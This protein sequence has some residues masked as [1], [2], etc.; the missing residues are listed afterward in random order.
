MDQPQPAPPKRKRRRLQWSL[1]LLLLFTAVCAVGMRFLLVPYWREATVRRWLDEIEASTTTAVV[2]PAWIRKIIGERFF[3]RVVGVDF[4]D[5][6][7]SDDD[8]EK[9]TRLPKL[10][11]VNL[12]KAPI[13]D[14]ALERLSHV[15]SLRELVL[16]GTA[17]TDDGLRHVESLPNLRRLWLGKT[18]VTLTALEHLMRKRPELRIDVALADNAYRSTWEQFQTHDVPVRHVIFRCEANEQ[19]KLLWAQSQGHAAGPFEAKQ[20]R[21][22]WLEKF[23]TRARELLA[24]KSKWLRPVDV[25]TLEAALAETQ[26]DLARFSPDPAAVASACRRGATSARRLLKLLTADLQAGTA[27]PFAFDHARDLATRLLLSEAWSKGE[28]ARHVDLLKDAVADQKKLL[29]HV[30]KLYTIG[31]PGGEPQRHALA[32]I[33]LAMAEAALAR[34]EKDPAAEL[35]ALEAALPMAQRVREAIRAHHDVGVTTTDELVLAYR[36]A[37]ALELALAQLTE[38]ADAA[39]AAR[40]TW[41]SSLVN[42]SDKALALW[43]ANSTMGNGGRPTTP[44]YYWNL[45]W[46]L[47]VLEQ[48]RERGPSVLDEPVAGLEPATSLVP[49]SVVPGFLEHWAPSREPQ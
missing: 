33:D 4:W 13:G 11:T 41:W 46:L 26:I 19:W 44:E 20:E 10:A 24:A 29:D 22:A 25:A 9:L 38:D 45:L 17:V 31:R 12:R 18:Q 16:I 48:M 7:V 47:S 21:A 32:T 1:R 37:E 43:A 14:S 49:R 5:C 3:E 35:A 39:H 8:L 34:A 15:E 2:G 28:Q 36:R 27:E 23:L 30:T 40:H 42:E 6:S